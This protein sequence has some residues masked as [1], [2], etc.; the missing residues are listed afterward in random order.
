[1]QR[2]DGSWDLDAAFAKAIGK[3]LATLEKALRGA[4]GDEATVRRALATA[5][6]I[7]WLDRHA[8]DEKGEWQ[9]LV[10]K[11]ADWLRTCGAVP[12]GGSG[13]LEL[14]RAMVR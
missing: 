3:R 9:M 8:A 2:A 11:G 1:L 12:A 5:I 14:G 10:R 6:A 4:N 7:T 13:W